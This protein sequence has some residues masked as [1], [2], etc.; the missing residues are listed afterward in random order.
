MSLDMSCEKSLSAVACTFEFL[1]VG[2]E[3]YYL[4]KRDT[5]LEG[6]FSQF[7]AVS[8]KGRKLEYEGILIDRAPPTKDEYILLKAGQKV[9]ATV[10]I[11]EVFALMHDGI[12]TVE[13]IKPLIVLNERKMPI[14][15]RAGEATYVRLENARYLSLPSQQD[16]VQSEG[17]ITIESC[18]T[19]TITGGTSS[20]RTD[21]LNAHK[22]LCKEFADSKV[23]VTNTDFYKTWW[24]T[25]T[26]AR[27]DK[28]K[29]VIDKCVDGLTNKAVTYVI[30][31]SNCQSNWNAYTRKGT[32]TVYLCPAYQNYQVYCISSGSATKE[33]ILAHEWSHAF[34]Y[35]DDNAYGA[36]ANKNLAKSDPDKAV[37]NADTYEYWYCLTQF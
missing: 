35:T 16:D 8:H 31:P 23:N 37:N 18:T 27:A 7:I 29:G 21:V 26:T 12:Y 20:Q 5:P 15:V 11:N 25:Y 32:T 1:N 13:Y 36:T 2:G 3:D 28:V 33:S 34:G 14:E 6:L 24:G 10:Q 4:L 30:N 9:S 19:A 17:T 22:K